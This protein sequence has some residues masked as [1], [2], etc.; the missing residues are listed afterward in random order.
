MKDD[1]FLI[2]VF[3]HIAPP[4]GQGLCGLL[5]SLT[6]SLK[7]PKV[8]AWSC[9]ADVVVFVEKLPATTQKLWLPHLMQTLHVLQNPIESMMSVL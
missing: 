3:M 9:N 4:L 2:P 5:L 8:Q 1:V 7:F 6:W